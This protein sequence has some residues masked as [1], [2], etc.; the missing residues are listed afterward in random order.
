MGDKL[1]LSKDK[2]HRSSSSLAYIVGGTRSERKI[3]I[4]GT[5]SISEVDEFTLAKIRC[6]ELQEKIDMVKALKRKKKLKRRSM[7]RVTEMKSELEKMPMIRVHTQPKKKT[8]HRSR[9]YTHKNVTQNDL[10]TFAHGVLEPVEVKAGGPDNDIKSKMKSLKQWDENAKCIPPNEPI[11]LNRTQNIDKNILIKQ[12]KQAS[13]NNNKSNTNKIYKSSREHSTSGFN[14]NHRDRSA[15]KTSDESQKS[16]DEERVG[17]GL[18][19]TSCR[20]RGYEMPTIAS[21]CKQADRKGDK[22]NSI[23]PFV[24]CESVT[25]SH[26][27]NINLQKVMHA[28]TQKQP[29]NGIPSTIAFTMGLTSSHLQS[30]SSLE[31]NDVNSIKVGKNFL[32]IPSFKMFYHRLLN[33][34]SEGDGM[35]PRQLRSD[36][37]PHYF[38]TS[39]YK[40]GEDWRNVRVNENIK[41]QQ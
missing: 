34:H 40:L 33:M 19:I 17:R 23:F 21:L 4:T 13:V 6:N 28:R 36:N 27:I 39:T 16:I 2:R 37:G 14:I 38:Y 24:I 25:P 22:K 12:S 29:V 11:N 8:A 15:S 10:A 35:I 18:A 1:K 41:C 7:T 32:R 5:A 30:I 31:I 3:N 9:I 20:R 26:N